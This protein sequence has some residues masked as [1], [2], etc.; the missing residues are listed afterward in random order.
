MVSK[1][2]N[3]VL[4]RTK[5]FVFPDQPQEVVAPNSEDFFIAQGDAPATPVRVESHIFG[6]NLVRTTIYCVDADL[7]NTGGFPGVTAVCQLCEIQNV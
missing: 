7:F 6:V 2:Q 5:V 4:A 1:E 3:P